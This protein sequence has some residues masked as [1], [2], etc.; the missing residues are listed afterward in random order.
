LTQSA[1]LSTSEAETVAKRAVQAFELLQ[2]DCKAGTLKL[3]LEP[4]KLLMAP[5]LD[6]TETASCQVSEG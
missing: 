6:E 1:G 4:K 5:G 2:A 3:D